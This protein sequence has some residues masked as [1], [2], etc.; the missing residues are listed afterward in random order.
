MRSSEH[1]KILADLNALIVSFEKIYETN[2]A[3]DPQHR[4]LENLIMMLSEAFS[5]FE[6]HDDQLE[7]E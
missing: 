7:D 3:N 6:Y 5:Y 1:K 4:H 2:G